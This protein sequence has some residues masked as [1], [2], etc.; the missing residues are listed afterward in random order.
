MRTNV[1]AVNLMKTFEGGQASPKIKPREQLLRQV[2]TCLLFEDAFYASGSTIA[3]EI[4]ETSKQLTLLEIGTIAILAR[5][6]MKLRH[7][8]LYLLALMDQ[9]RAEAPYLVAWAINEVIH[10]VDEMPELLALIQRLSGGKP[11]KKVISAQV[12]KGLARVFPKFNAYQLAKWN[13]D[14]AIKL[15]DVLFLTHPK[16]KDS[17][18]ATTWKSLIDGNLAAPDTWEVA[19]SAGAD[20]KETWERLLRENKLGYMA[21][22][23]NVRN[24]TEAG[25]DRALV[26][27]SLLDGAKGSWALPFR[28]ISAMK[29]APGYAQELSDAM[30]SALS[31]AEK[32]EGS[33]AIVVDV[34]G[35]MAT[36]LSGKSQM[37]RMEAAGALA[38]MV[39]EI[40]PV[41]SVYSFSQNLVEVRNLRGLGL[42][43]AIQQSQP[44]SSTYLRGAVTTLLANRPAD[45][46][47]VIT[48]EQSNDGTIPPLPEG[49]RGYIVNVAP[50]RPGLEMAGGWIRINGFSERIVDFIRYE[51]KGTVGVVEAE[52]VA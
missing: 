33:T 36:A 22:L 31:S 19:L 20:K 35:S 50:Y 51:E 40:C 15:K 11:L 24:L 5:K 29:A 14:S 16:P 42:M 27:K 49:K 38:V 52:G 26:T 4:A 6:E 30:V 39:R 43:Q 23:M 25:V 41:V 13:R 18:Q 8:P 1:T 45:R 28:F 12:K 2:S 37:S 3:A 48:D 32:L 7:V 17:E 9:R 47:I 21:L 46:I 34:S 44:N 10:R